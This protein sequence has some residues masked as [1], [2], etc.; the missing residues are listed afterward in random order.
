M[1]VPLS[2]LDSQMLG[3]PY[4]QIKLKVMSLC[5]SLLLFMEIVLG[6]D[7]T[8]DEEE[9]LTILQKVRRNPNGYKDYYHTWEEIVEHDKRSDCWVVVH[10][11]VY[12]LTNFVPIHP[13]GEIIYDGAGGDCTPMWESYHPLETAKSRPAEKYCIGYVRDYYDFYSWDGEFYDVLRKRVEEAIPREYR[14]YDPRMYAKSAVILITWSICFYWY[15]MYNTWQ[16]A[17]V[18]GLISGQVGV[19]IM[20]DGNHMAYSTNKW[21]NTLAGN[22]LE[23]LGTSAIIYKRS[24]NFGH[25]GC[26]NHLELDRAFDTTF[27]LLRFHRGLPLINYHKFQWIYGPILYSFLNFGEMFGQYDEIYWLSNFPVRR[28]NISMKAV[29]A[30]TFVIV[31]Y[32]I[33]YFF[34][35]MYYFGYTH[36]YSIWMLEMMVN[37]HSYVWFF[38]VNHWTAEAGMTDFMNISETNWG[39]L[40][41]ENSCNFAND[42]PLWNFLSGGL[43]FQ[44]EHHLFPG[45]IHTRYSDIRPI[46]K[47]T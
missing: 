39:V 43:N 27:P 23:L 46:V 7:Y 19:N 17:I 30:R 6:R 22:S 9:T 5:V 44:I 42:S 15:L 3:I 36:F 33:F 13:G 10:G 8:K 29:L 31:L 28:G 16:S 34:W 35:P 14:R 18:F 26:V 12:D 37:S 2:I 20:H 24:H 45:Y 47:K 25:H 11:K 40:Q 21:M 41:V 32:F 4:D 38:A 1:T